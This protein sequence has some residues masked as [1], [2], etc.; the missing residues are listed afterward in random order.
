MAQTMQYNHIVKFM[1]IFHP[2]NSPTIATEKLETH[3][4][5]YFLSI[6]NHKKRPLNAISST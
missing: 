3:H 1:V 4:G 5:K 2:A 6:L